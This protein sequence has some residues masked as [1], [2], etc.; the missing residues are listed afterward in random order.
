[1]VSLS[2]QTLCP[3]SVDHKFPLCNKGTCGTLKLGVFSTEAVYNEVSYTK[4]KTGICHMNE[5]CNNIGMISWCN[6]IYG[7][8]QYGYCILGW[9][10]MPLMEE[11]DRWGHVLRIWLCWYVFRNLWQIFVYTFVVFSWGK[12]VLWN[13]CNIM[14]LISFMMDFA[15]IMK[16]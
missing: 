5:G 16:F 4:K 11:Y 3:K 13:I 6:L 15:S 14:N 1:M 12:K 10:L 9:I 8:I 2:P 7:G